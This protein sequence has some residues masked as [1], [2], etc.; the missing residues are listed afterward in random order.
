MIRTLAFLLVALVVSSN[1]YADRYITHFH[2]Y[3]HVGVAV[4]VWEQDENGNWVVTG[5]V[6]YDFKADPTILNTL[7]STLYGNGK[8][9]KTDGLN[10]Q[11]PITFP[12]DHEEDQVL[13]DWLEGQVD[14]PQFYSALAHNCIFWSVGAVCVGIKSDEQK[15]AEFDQLLP[16]D[17]PYNN[18]TPET[19]WEEIVDYYNSLSP[20][21]QKEL[22]P[23]GIE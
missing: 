6:T 9:V 11:D 10:L 21:R 1:A 7:A 17:D 3:N 18:F 19:P 23:N 20:E 8:I 12:S 22:F 4:D 16:S 5:Q 15:D 2:G 13:T 14:E